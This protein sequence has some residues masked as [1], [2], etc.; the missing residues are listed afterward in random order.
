MNITVLIIGRQREI[1]PDEEGN[2]PTE[3]G[4]SAAGFEDEQRSPKQG[5]QGMQH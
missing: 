5:M 2:V 3:A 4:C 1:Y